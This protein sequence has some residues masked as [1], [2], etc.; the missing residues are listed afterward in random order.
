MIRVC[1]WSRRD[2]PPERGVD[3]PTCVGDVRVR[4]GRNGRQSVP[5]AE[6]AIRSPQH[7]S[8]PGMRPP[9]SARSSLHERCMPAIVPPRPRNRS[10]LTPPSPL[11]RDPRAGVLLLRHLPVRS[12]VEPT[13]KDG[14]AY[15]RAPVFP[16]RCCTDIG[17]GRLACMLATGLEIRVAQGRTPLAFQNPSPS[18]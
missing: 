15:A 13:L 18:M 17:R 1:E 3:L 16:D 8:G 5:P 10:S 4:N 14:A 2:H 6:G 11:V 9:R 12:G 7:T